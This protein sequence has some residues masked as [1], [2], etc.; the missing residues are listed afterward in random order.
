MTEEKVNTTPDENKTFITIK[1]TKFEISPLDAKKTIFIAN[2]FGKLLI[3][4]KVKLNEFKGLTGGDLPFAI[5]ATLDETT[6][7]SLAATLIGSDEK[8]AE[9]NFELGWVTE[10]LLVQVQVS[11]LDAVIR[12][13]TALFTQLV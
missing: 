9:E 3:S 11:D 7:V 8:F 6:L 4:G 10:A 5:L 1:G 2:T 13:F 12:N